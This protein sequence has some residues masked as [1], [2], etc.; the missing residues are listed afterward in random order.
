MKRSKILVL[1]I[2]VLLILSLNFFSKEARS[3]FYAISSPVQKTFWGAGNGISDFFSGIF[4]GESLKRENEELKLENQKLL[5]EKAFL[6]KVTEENEL[7]RQALGIGLAEE[8]QLG[9]ASV[10][11]KLA[12]EAVLIDKG[13]ED[14]FS[15]NMPVI[16]AENV[17]V[18]K[19]DKVYKKF[20]R[21]ALISQKENSFDVEISGKNIKGLIRGKGSSEIFLDLVSKDKELK[22]G[23]LVVSSSFGGT[24]PEGLLVGTVKEVINS[25]V[26][27][28][29]QAE[30]SPFLDLRELKN[31]FII[32]S[33]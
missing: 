28:F 19:I 29:Q 32:L 16:T 27:P 26:Q 2:A 33:F 6:N 20:S 13:A 8:F 9:F 1:L 3:F 18:G 14:G 25:D 4:S 17:L 5:A 23:D 10:V 22:K 11:S 24:Y 31:V 15:E 21:V 7:L 30:V 12:D